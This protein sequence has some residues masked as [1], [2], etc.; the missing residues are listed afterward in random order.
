LSI[1]GYGKIESQSESDRFKKF[2]P[3]IS[4][5][6]IHLCQARQRDPW[7]REQSTTWLIYGVRKP[8]TSR[9]FAL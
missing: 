8:L 2:R 4:L 9:Q 1:L 3:N 7:D 5:L 6:L